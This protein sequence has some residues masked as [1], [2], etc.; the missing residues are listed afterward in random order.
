MKT[1]SILF[2]LINSII[3]CNINHADE[4]NFGKQTPSAKQVINALNPGT[5]SSDT[6]DVNSDYEGDINKNDSKSRSINMGALK[7]S[8][9]TKAKPKS[10]IQ[11][12]SQNIG[13]ENAHT[14]TALSMEIM[15]GYKSAELTENAKIQL[16]P[17][18]EALS[19]NDLQSLNFIVEGHTDAIGSDA[20]NINLSKE[21]AAAVKQYL[22]TNF[23]ISPSRIQITGKGK[24]NLLD[25]VN[26]DSEVNRRVRIVV[27]K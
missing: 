24:N 5:S 22:I 16:K 13:I 21:R 11:N 3:F 25:P 6:P 9:Q 18:G 19:S 1:K 23:H 4:I 26:P 7:A 20:Y 2:F 8:P 12:K 14:E 27:L 17:V 15:F 10:K